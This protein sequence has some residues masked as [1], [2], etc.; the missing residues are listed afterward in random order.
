MTTPLMISALLLL[1]AALLLLSSLFEQRRR[2]RQI[3]RRL[4]GDLLRQNRFGNLLQLGIELDQSCP[5][6]ESRKVDV[7]AIIAE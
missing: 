7:T 5:V 1:G 4:E 3:S 2:A 6:L